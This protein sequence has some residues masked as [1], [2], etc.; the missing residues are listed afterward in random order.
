[1]AKTILFPKDMGMPLSPSN[2]LRRPVAHPLVVLR[3]EFDDWA[4][5]YNPETGAALGLNPTGVFIWQ[6]IDGKRSVSD[7]MHRV[8]AYFADV[9]AEAAEQVA[10]FVET[11]ASKGFVGFEARG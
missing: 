11:L 5:L 1:V 6:A 7:L 9:P 4:V 3:E 10:G 2:L 8:E